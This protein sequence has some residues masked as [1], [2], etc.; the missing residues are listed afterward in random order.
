[1]NRTTVGGPELGGGRGAGSVVVLSDPAAGA[2]S[3]AVAP[4]VAAALFPSVHLR[5]E[6]FRRAVRQGYVEAD[7]PEARR[8]NLTALAAT[9]QAA[10]AFA[11]GG[12]QVVVEGSVAPTALDTFR[13]ES[14]ATGAALHY[15]VLHGGAVAETDG[16]AA[17]GDDDAA[18]S[19]A[20]ATAGTVLAGLRRGAYLLGW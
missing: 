7:R 8:Q 13:R 17:D 20:E 1:M 6:D 9:A 5:A 16:P 10:F 14:R 15:V 19:A 3:G 12:Y 2:G 18:V 4:L 11:A